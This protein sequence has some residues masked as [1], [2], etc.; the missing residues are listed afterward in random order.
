MYIDYLFLQFIHNC[1]TSL[2]FESLNLFLGFYE[3]LPELLEGLH[4][5]P[6]VLLVVSL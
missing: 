2:S 1:I 5:L 3:V 6:V 4:P